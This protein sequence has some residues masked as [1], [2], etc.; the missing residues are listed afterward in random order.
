MI[1]TKQIH[2]IYHINLGQSFYSFPLRYAAIN[3]P[4]GVYF[5]EGYLQL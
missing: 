4:Q 3:I 5:F 2:Q 1:K